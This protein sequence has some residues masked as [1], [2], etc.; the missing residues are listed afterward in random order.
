[1]WIMLYTTK[2]EDHDTLFPMS[3]VGRCTIR[4]VNS[5]PKLEGADE[6]VFASDR[7]Q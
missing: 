2:S 4:E 6:I 1:V 7:S 3:S 5:A